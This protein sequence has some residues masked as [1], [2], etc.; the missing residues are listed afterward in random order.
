MNQLLQLNELT[1][2]D[3]RQQQIKVAGSCCE[4]HP[5]EQNRLFCYDCKV[6]MCPRCINKHSQHKLADVTESAKNFRKQ[7]KTHIDKVS[8]RA[9]RN[10]QK[11]QRLKTDTE[12]FK[13]KV[14][15]TQS[16][17]SQK[18]DQLISHI[19]SQKSQ[20]IEELNIFRDKMLKDVETDKD[21][22]ETQFVI[23]ESFKRYC[24]EMMSQGS[25]CD[26]VSSLR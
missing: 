26:L 6:V 5:E 20:L 1:N 13:N 8:A 7:I 10:Q 21:K 4:Q 14:A 17:I 2:T 23:T 18:Y 9:L 25:A 15:S 11:L 3:R 24:Q 12:S 16:D 22:I 19:K